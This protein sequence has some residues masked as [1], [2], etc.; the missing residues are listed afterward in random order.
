MRVLQLD[1]RSWAV[2]GAIALFGC[3]A[4]V[5]STADAEG[6]EAALRRPSQSIAFEAFSDPE[7][8]GSAGERPTSRL[9]RSA[10][11]YERLLGHAPPAEVDFAAGDVV[12]FYS[13]GIQS[14]GGYEASILEVALRNRQLQVTTQLVSPGEDCIVTQALTTPYVLARV[15]PPRRVNGA[16]FE[17]VDV[18][19]DCSEE[20]P[21]ATVR[22][23]VGT[24]CELQ[25]DGTA[26]CVPNGPFCGGIAGFLCP[27]GG[28]CVD[29]PTDDCDPNMGGADCGGICACLSIGLCVDGFVWDESPDVCGCVPEDGGDVHPCAAVLCP[30]DTTCELQNGEP[31]CVPA[32]NQ[33]C[34]NATC[35]AGQVCC[36]W[37]CGICT[38][39]GGFCTEQFCGEPE[40]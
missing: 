28:Q 24:I 18:I 29:D 40:A 21:C 4:D 1:A 7:G 22:C 13:A 33:Q 15:R 12:I 16:R 2:L 39:P 10:R 35:E 34:G 27:G 36:N 9:I 11:Q 31:I 17:H 25:A 20:D 37:S 32:D 38:E 19:R 5:G 8:V 30:I 26:A 14:T 6:S 23:A 3:A